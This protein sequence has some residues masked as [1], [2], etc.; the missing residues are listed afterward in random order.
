MRKVEYELY[1]P[2]IITFL[3]E[4]I[5]KKRLFEVC[6]CINTPDGVGRSGKGHLGGE[7]G[8]SYWGKEKEDIAT[9]ANRE[10]E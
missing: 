3:L 7:K 9:T 5:I 1:T 2:R 4:K 8:R 6:T 10:D